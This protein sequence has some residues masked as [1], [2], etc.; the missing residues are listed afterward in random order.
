MIVLNCPHCKKP[1][2]YAETNPATLD[3]PHCEKSFKSLGRLPKPDWSIDMGERF[4]NERVA[5]A[6]LPK[7]ACGYCGKTCKKNEYACGRCLCDLNQ[8]ATVNVK[9]WMMDLDVDP[10]P[11][12]IK[13]Y[14]ALGELDIDEEEALIRLLRM[15]PRAARDM[16]ASVELAERM[17]YMEPPPRSEA[18]KKV[19]AQERADDY[20]A[21][22]SWQE[23]AF[24]ASLKGR[25]FY[26]LALGA[27]FYAASATIGV[28]LIA[29]GIGMVVWGSIALLKF[30]IVPMGV[31]AGLLWAIAP[32]FDRFDPPWPELTEEEYPRLF[33]VI[34]EIAT[35]TGQKEPD[36]V[37]AVPDV[38]AFVAQRGGLL[39]FGG[40]R[41][42]GIGWP[43]M[44]AFTIS[45][46]KAVLAHEFGHFHGGDTQRGP[47][48]YRIREA[49]G[50]MLN[51]IEEDEEQTGNK[52][53]IWFANHFIAQSKI[54]SRRQEY[55]ADALAAKVMGPTAVMNGFHK[56]MGVSIAFNQYFKT[57][58]DPILDE[59]MRV[60][61]AQGFQG[62][63]ESEATQKLLETT[64]DFSQFHTDAHPFDS[65]P[66]TGYRIKNVA[67]FEDPAIP[68]ETERA[69]TL[70]GDLEALEEATYASFNPEVGFAD[71]PRFEWNEVIDRF[72]LPYWKDLLHHH[73]ARLEGL[74]LGDLPKLFRDPEP[75]VSDWGI[76]LSDYT[77]QEMGDLFFTPFRAGLAVALTERGWTLQTKPGDPFTA[78]KDG[79]TIILNDLVTG[80][81]EQE[82]DP[83]WTELV[84]E[85]DLA[86]V[87][88]T[89]LGAPEQLKNHRK[90]MQ[91]QTK[92]P[93]L[94]ALFP[95]RDRI[96][97]T[98]T[99]VL[100]FPL[101]FG[102]LI[103]DLGLVNWLALLVL[104]MP[105]ITAVTLPILQYRIA[106]RGLGHWVMDEETVQFTV[107]E[108]STAIRFQDVQELKM[109]KEVV[110]ND[111]EEFGIWWTMDIRS[112]NETIHISHFREAGQSGV[113]AEEMIQRLGIWRA[114]TWVKQI[115]NGGTA[116]GQGWKADQYG[117]QLPRQSE[118]LPWDT[119]AKPSWNG[120]SIVFHQSG[121]IAPALTLPHHAPEAM[122][123]WWI[124][125]DK[126]TFEGQTSALGDYLHSERRRTGYGFIFS[127]IGS[128]TAFFATMA[129]LS[130]V[131]KGDNLAVSL[132]AFAACAAAYAALSFATFRLRFR[133]KVHAHENG[134]RIS[135]LWGTKTVNFDE[136]I[137]L[138]YT[139]SDSDPQFTTVW[140]RDRHK[141]LKFKYNA[142]EDQFI[143]HIVHGGA[144]AVARNAFNQ[145]AEGGDWTW[146]GKISINR[147]GVTVSG[148]NGF[149]IPLHKVRYGPDGD[150]TVVMHETKEELI[151]AYDADNENGL[152]GM[153]LLKLLQ[154]AD[155]MH[156]EGEPPVRRASR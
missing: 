149:K 123:L 57:E 112:A 99:A 64:T 79:R 40:K 65:H 77:Q 70:L 140:L 141:R 81:R 26:L 11:S 14:Q 20:D 90:R 102:L 80:A 110:A 41:I 83:L 50:R 85:T 88:L 17:Q 127:M 121:R 62:F 4:Y 124:G 130:S 131:A 135:G 82:V 145:I 36:H 132:P 10:D 60:P 136:L 154:E 98:W 108:Q 105:F 54:V 49:I 18:A 107:G 78:T 94:R 43:L 34:R 74:C 133:S 69:V 129:F 58:V 39:G 23:E 86:T 37:Y 151:T 106:R 38:N 68:P 51:R 9:Q 155:G 73:Q 147:E 138:R 146:S 16:G 48:I 35:K 44:Q 71:F 148:K 2:T 53:F 61:L 27:L 67:R 33:A 52:L 12:V 84:A 45:E 5:P 156:R 30:A 76:D 28:A 7:R 1:A 97:M 118:P 119:L 150:Q 31:G 122:T 109:R 56:I 142:V 87:K 59:G 89:D 137:G 91:L 13:A 126:A 46:F 24:H 55:N 95:T 125:I 117:L 114:D 120:D 32:R 92:K 42:M 21:D 143:N 101:A 152:A 104:A 96:I 15:H 3:C 25:V 6:R 19:L 116:A 144:R 113:L 75:H 139:Y 103:L 29:F 115:D 111:E 66:P 93:P 134:V 72:Y 153:Y 63:L 100:G 47:L 8:V 22:D 128:A